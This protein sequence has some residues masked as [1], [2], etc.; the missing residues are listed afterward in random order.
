MNANFVSRVS[1]PLRVRRADRL[2]SA[3]FVV[4]GGVSACSCAIHAPGSFAS[5]GTDGTTTRLILGG[6]RF[7]RLWQHH[8]LLHLFL[9]GAEFGLPEWPHRCWRLN[10][11]ERSRRNLRSRLYFWRWGSSRGLAQR[12]QEFTDPVRVGLRLGSLDGLRVFRATG[13]ARQLRRTLRS[14]LRFL[15]NARNQSRD[16]DDRRDDDED[17]V[18]IPM[19]G[20]HGGKIVKALKS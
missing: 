5:A 8:D 11:C 14:F 18:L 17:D 1:P 16:A 12:L 7:G 9:P 10:W 20:E 15:R 6:D 13:S 4:A 2:G 19:H 3:I